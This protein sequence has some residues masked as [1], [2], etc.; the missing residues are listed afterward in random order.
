MMELML[1]LMKR[2]TTEPLGFCGSIDI[3]NAVMRELH[4]IGVD[5]WIGN[6]AKIT[7]ILPGIIKAEK[8]IRD[9]SKEVSPEARRVVE[10]LMDATVL[11]E[12]WP[13][14]G[15]TVGYMDEDGNEHM[16]KLTPEEADGE[17]CVIGV[18]QQGDDQ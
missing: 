14:E 9:G 8:I 5:I 4:G 6:C 12:K 17:F 7:K 18:R 15:M 16:R 11:A 3:D 13:G 10:W 2:D 1:M